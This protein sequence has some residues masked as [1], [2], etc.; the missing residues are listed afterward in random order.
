MLEPRIV[1]D[2]L[3]KLSDFRGLLEVDEDAHVILDE[4]GGQADGVLRRDCAV[5]PHL[6]HE[7]FVVGHLAKTRGFDRI[8]DLA[9]RRVD[10]VHR[11]VADGQ[12][13]VIVA[14]GG[15]VPAAILRAHFDLQLATF[16]DGG[17]VH[18]LIEH[19]EIRIFFYLRVGYRPRGLDVDVTR[20]RH[21][22]VELDGHL[23][24]VKN[25]VGGIFHYA[26][27]RRKFV[28]DSFDF[29]CGNG[30]AFN[31]AEE[32]TPQG[33][34]YGRAPAALKRLRREAAVLLR[35]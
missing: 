13:L 4:L 19:C 12:V 21:V 29:Y 15:D 33:V 11:N 26:G 8:V 18:G 16:T 35:Q 22:R 6:D 17:D 30:G 32:R 9:N 1:G 20:F 10:G 24:E 25:N 2:F 27:D 7:L 23:L 3:R 34:A 14:V 28:Q 31:G 5:G